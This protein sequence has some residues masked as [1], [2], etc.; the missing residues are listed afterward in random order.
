MELL[1]KYRVPMP[2]QNLSDADIRDYLEYF[3]WADANL[4]AGGGGLVPGI[5]VGLHLRRAW[6]FFPC[7]FLASA[8]GRRP[9]RLASAIHPRCPGPP[10]AP[11]TFYGTLLKNPGRE[12]GTRGENR[13][14][15]MP[16]WLSPACLLPLFR[17]PPSTPLRSSTRRIWPAHS[18]ILRSTHREPVS[19]R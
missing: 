1:A 8:N 7:D 12:P 13:H 3:R 11:G 10:V 9:E 17:S 4:A 16:C 15:E 2:N 6:K 14:E 5:D 19:R 18:K